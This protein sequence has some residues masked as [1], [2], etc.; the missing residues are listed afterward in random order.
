VY[1]GPVPPIPPSLLSGP[2][3]VERQLA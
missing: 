1:R 3:S 2:R